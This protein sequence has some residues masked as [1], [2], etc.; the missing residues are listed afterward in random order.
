MTDIQ[1]G[2]GKSRLLLDNKVKK[3]TNKYDS[4]NHFIPTYCT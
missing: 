4:L 3:N 1:N 2:Y